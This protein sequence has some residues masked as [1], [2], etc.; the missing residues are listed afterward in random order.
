[1]FGLW[2]MI[3]VCVFEGDDCICI[4]EYFW[5]EGV[6]FWCLLCFV[7]FVWFLV[8]ECFDF[9]V[10]GVQSCGQCGVDQVGGFV[11]DDL[12]CYGGFLMFELNGVVYVMFCVMD[13]EF[14]VRCYQVWVL[15]GLN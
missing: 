1:M 10:I 15:L 8:D 14:G 7:F 12:L 2:Q 11:D 9:Y 4:G 13:F 6:F 5:V 3:D